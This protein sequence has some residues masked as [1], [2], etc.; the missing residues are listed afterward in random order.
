MCI[1]YALDLLINTIDFHPGHDFKKFSTRGNGAAS[2][3]GKHF[4]PAAHFVLILDSITRHIYHQ[5]IHIT[6]IYMIHQIRQ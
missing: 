4:G 5:I 3:N 2:T 6:G 1:Y